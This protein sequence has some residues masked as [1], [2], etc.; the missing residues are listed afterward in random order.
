[1]KFLFVIILFF[2]LLGPILRFLLR[3]FV[4]NK[5]MKEQVKAQKSARREGDIRVEN[6][7]PHRPQR[8]K[9]SDGQYIDYEEIK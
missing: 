7:A 5:V 2:I 1:M 9:D 8:T 6:A 3:M 4:M